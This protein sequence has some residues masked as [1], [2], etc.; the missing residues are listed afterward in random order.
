MKP[1]R[2]GEHFFIGFQVISLCP[3]TNID[4]VFS[5]LVLLHGYD[6]YQ[7]QWCGLRCFAH[8]WGGALCLLLQFL[9]NSHIFRE[10][11]CPF[12]LASSI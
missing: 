9:F 1:D 4:G 11:H 3:L 5:S 6:R 8:L 10:Q 2:R 12:L 7:E